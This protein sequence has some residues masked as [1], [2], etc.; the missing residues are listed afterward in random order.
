M[1]D[2]VALADVALAGVELADVAF[3]DMAFADV[4][5]TN[6]VLA[7]AVYTVVILTDVAHAAAALADVALVAAQDPVCWRRCW[8]GD[9]RAGQAAST[10][11]DSS[12]PCCGG[13]A[14]SWRQP[15]SVPLGTAS[16]RS[17]FLPRAPS[18]GCA[19]LC[20]ADEWIACHTLLGAFRVLRPSPCCLGSESA[21]VSWAP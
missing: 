10:F 15:C 20:R 13:A 6:A 7:D 11:R 3:A 2:N 16:P 17:R 18:L 4:A 1:V 8:R 21:L 9:G 12:P 5:L 19:F 14:R